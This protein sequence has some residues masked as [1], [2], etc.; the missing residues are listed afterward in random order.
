[1][2]N[3]SNEIAKNCKDDGYPKGLAN[4]VYKIF[5]KKTGSQDLHKAVIKKFKSRKV[6]ARF[7]YKVWVAYLAEM[8]SLSSLIC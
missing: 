7:K 2:K 4:M 1:M 8:R 5:D 3:R 6:Y